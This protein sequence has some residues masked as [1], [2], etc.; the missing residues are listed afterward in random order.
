MSE[1]NKVD[2]ERALAST[3]KPVCAIQGCAYGGNR[4][5]IK[6]GKEYCAVHAESATF[7]LTKEEEA[8]KLLEKFLQCID[9][10]GKVS[11]RDALLETSTVDSKEIERKLSANVTDE[12]KR[13]ILE[14]AIS[15]CRS[16]HLATDEIKAQLERLKGNLS[17]CVTVAD[18]VKMTEADLETDKRKLE[19]LEAAERH[20]RQVQRD[21][22]TIARRLQQE[23][24]G[25]A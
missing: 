9:K 6:N 5:Y 4:W 17:R 24:L 12:Q 14:N 20:Q 23:R 25:N 16:E 11:F 18:L 13:Q 21:M 22:F 1:S 7:H 10:D 3:T 8:K 15:Q 19:A 2:G